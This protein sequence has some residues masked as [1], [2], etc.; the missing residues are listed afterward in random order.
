MVLFSHCSRSYACRGRSG[1]SSKRS[2]LSVPPPVDPCRSDAGA[3]PDGP[4]DICPDE[5][6]DGKTTAEQVVRI[7]L[8]CKRILC[9]ND[10]SSARC[11]KLIGAL[12]AAVDGHAPQAPSTVSFMHRATP[13]VVSAVVL[14]RRAEPRP[15][16]TV[17]RRLQ[18]TGGPRVS[19]S[20]S[21]NARRDSSCLHIP[22]RRA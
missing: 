1:L 19:P 8:D 2:A 17:R 10:C 3:G 7:I 14:F 20:R 21:R 5:A 22:R 11:G 12:P 4:P 16:A 18:M 6:R 13:R 9:R 15:C